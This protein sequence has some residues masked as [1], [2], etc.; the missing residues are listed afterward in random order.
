[1]AMFVEMCFHI[2]VAEMILVGIFGAGMFCLSVLLWVA[3][4]Y[5]G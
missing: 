3:D 4:K 5:G 2:V 1:M